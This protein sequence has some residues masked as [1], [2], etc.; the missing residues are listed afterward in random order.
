MYVNLL[1]QLSRLYNVEYCMYDYSW[2]GCN[3]VK[4]TCQEK[5]MEMGNTSSNYISNCP[6]LTVGYYIQL[7]VMNNYSLTH[8]CLLC[9]VVY[10]GQVFITNIYPL[11]KNA[12]VHCGQ[13][14][15]M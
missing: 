10:Y 4:C 12:F 8:S 9:T 13:I 3:I 5:T 15:I 2:S 11:L 14:L 1:S 6:L 7:Y